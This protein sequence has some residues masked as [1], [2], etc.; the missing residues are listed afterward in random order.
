MRSSS[1]LSLN[2]RRGA[3]ALVLMGGLVGASFA[4]S[5]DTSQ[6]PKTRAEVRAE[7]VRLEQ[8]GYNP[9]ESN[10]DDYPQNIQAAEARVARE[11]AQRA[12]EHAPAQ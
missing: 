3:L 8:A 1:P 7:L 12:A 9:A 6:Q 5:V 4:Q 2:V 10:A 11:D